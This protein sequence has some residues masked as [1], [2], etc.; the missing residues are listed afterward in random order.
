[1][2]APLSSG[3]TFTA[4]ELW[5][6][7]S[8]SSG[9][10]LTP[11]ETE[12]HIAL[13]DIA[14]A[15]DA[16]AATSSAWRHY[17]PTMQRAVKL[18]TP[19]AARNGWDEQVYTEYETSP[20]EHA[21]LGAVAFR[22]GT[23]WVVAIEDGSQ[24]TFEKRQA[25]A[26]LVFQSLRPAGYVRE[27][28]TGRAPH[29]LDAARIEQLRNFVAA[30]MRELGVPGVG[31]ALIQHARIVFEGGLGV[32]QLG[33]PAPVDAHTLFMIAS[34]TKG[35]STLLLAKLADKGK[36]AW[37]Q[38]VV[39]LYPAFRLG[40]STTTQS[41]LV[42]HLVC[43][44]TGLPRKDDEI[45][46][47]TGAHTPPSQTFALLAGT[48]PTSR[49]GEVFQY[50]NLMAAAAG[51]I[52]AHLLFP[53][54]DLG[55][56]Y[57]TAM[58]QEIFA[59]L[60]MTDT[61]FD[62][63]RALAADHASP[64]ADDID[65][66]PQIVRMDFNTV[67]TPFRPAGGAWSSAHDMIRYVQDELTEGLLPDGTRLVSAKNLL[68]RRVPNVAM[69]E[70]QTYG[71]GLE[72]N[73]HWGVAVIHH[74][75]SLAGFKSDILAVPA[76]GVGAVILT[77]GQYGSALLKPFMRRL[78]EVLYDGRPEAEGDVAAS[79]ERIDAEMAKDRERLIVP[80]S[81]AD[82]QTLAAHYASPELGT[83]AVGASRDGITFDFGA[84]HSCVAARH[85]DDG[86]LSFI[87]IDPGTQGLAFVVGR[88]NGRRILV[89]RDGQHRYVYTEAS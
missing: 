54:Q 29:T 24:A 35:L 9:V 55:T 42:R 88:E 67:F 36:L 7:A 58:Q 31:L 4:P 30:G 77:N 65:G 8:S 76:A 27:T 86:T 74:G 47:A 56:A 2:A 85:N 1:V 70:D 72:T 10:V 62:M 50:N 78:L 43:A 49:F 21:E 87:T 48:Q 34:N 60:G 59:P 25:A 15:A 33:Q 26:A 83:I 81:P 12:S 89:I 17:R 71:M 75:G 28:F 82:T 14:N 73:T 32:K 79:A 39:D 66:K 22:A 41:V 84:W 6:I 40:D 52:G 46:F 38:R 18:A 57:D 23:H 5:S 19:R 51:Y 80:P 20:N 16:A 3:A 64:H 61:T 63:A 13:V 44:C 45:M 69:G 53:D 11:P 37:D 68:Q